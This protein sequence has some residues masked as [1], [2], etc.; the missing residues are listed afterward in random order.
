LVDASETE[1][2]SPLSG[3]IMYAALLQSNNWPEPCAVFRGDCRSTDSGGDRVVIHTADAHGFG[4][5]WTRV[6]G[7]EGD[8]KGARE[9]GREER[10][11]SM[12][13]EEGGK[14]D[15]N[16]QGVALT[17]EVAVRRRAMGR[18]VRGDTRSTVNA[19]FNA[20]ATHTFIGR[21]TRDR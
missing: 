9:T 11:G 6:G 10:K 5:D 8:S 18:R 21:H 19:L 7:G 14:E 20:R 17:D 13:G 3:R 2:S 4:G 15:N 12:E 1:S 16:R